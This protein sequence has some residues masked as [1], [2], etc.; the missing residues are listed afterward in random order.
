MREGLNGRL[1]L[2]LYHQE[3]RPRRMTRPCYGTE[4]KE[5]DSWRAEDYFEKMVWRNY[6]GQHADLFEDSNVDG[7]INEMVCGERGVRY[8][9]R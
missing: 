2:R 4:A 7:S 6:V 1:F 5:G 9:E 8:H 3:V